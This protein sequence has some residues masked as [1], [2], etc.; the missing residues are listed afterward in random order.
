MVGL[1]GLTFQ[2]S[3]IDSVYML[4]IYIPE[5]SP[6][7]TLKHIQYD[8]LPSSLHCPQLPLALLCQIPHIQMIRKSQIYCHAE[9]DSAS[10]F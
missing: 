8:I 1:L 4:K 10:R 6:C 3:R 7:Q 9:L 2:A 5:S